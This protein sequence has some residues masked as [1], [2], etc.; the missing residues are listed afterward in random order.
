[1]STTEQIED[2]V[3]AVLRH[4]GPK[5]AS[6]IHSKDSPTC[7]GKGFSSIRYLSSKVGSGTGAVLRCAYLHQLYATDRPHSL[8]LEFDVATTRPSA[9]A[10]V[11]CN[12][13]PTGG[14]GS[15]DH[16]FR[17]LDSDSFESVASASSLFAVVSKL[18]HSLNHDLPKTLIEA[19][20]N[21]KTNADA[22]GDPNL[23]VN[24]MHQTEAARQILWL[25]I[26]LL[27]SAAAGRNRSELCSPVPVPLMSHSKMLDGDVIANYIF[28]TTNKM[29]PQCFGKQSGQKEQNEQEMMWSFLLSLPWIL[30]ELKVDDHDSVEKGSTLSVDI[31]LDITAAL[32]DETPHFAKL[33]KEQGVV[34]A[35]HGTKVENVWSILNYGLQNLSYHKTL[36][37][38]GAMLGEGV[39]LSTAYSVAAMFA[40]M[41]ARYTPALLEAW[42]HPALLCLI[43][44]HTSTLDNT[45]T[46]TGDVG[47]RNILDQYT[48][49]CYP[50]FQATIIAPPEQENATPST[51]CTRRDG[52]YYVVPNSED[53]RI[54]R[55]HLTVELKR[56]TTALGS[57]PPTA[58]SRMLYMIT[59]LVVLLSIF[60]YFVPV[61][62][63]EE[64]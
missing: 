38:N 30:G 33:A 61:Y 24:G 28:S 59:I 53:I 40:K 13:R 49:T 17:H 35:W 54:T 21:N 14:D 15:D 36:C 22:N 18:L 25:Q 23:M 29:M 19:T 1:M 63:E 6:L 57:W 44:D 26:L 46:N 12:G 20:C 45:T 9:V 2:E 32:G 64:F 39:Y 4:F 3:T 31:T 7:S 42:Q 43:R 56:K 62:Y 8:F 55:L 50:V 47:S 48:V 60:S 37:K 5:F 58:C 51:N 10:C 16:Q 41:D 52:K 34:T 27:R 11:S